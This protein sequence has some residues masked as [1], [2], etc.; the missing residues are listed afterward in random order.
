[1]L[2]K[3]DVML[4]YPNPFVVRHVPDSE[5]RGKI[6]QE[7]VDVKG[8]ISADKCFNNAHQYMLYHRL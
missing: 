6:I 4:V 1:M 5:H 8:S 2:L 3:K 7:S